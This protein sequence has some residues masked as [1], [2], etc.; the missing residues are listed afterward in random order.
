MADLEQE[1]RLVEAAQQNPDCFNELYQLYFDKIY[2]FVLSRASS[3]ELAEDITSQTFM[4]ALENI[5]RFKWRN[6]SFG[7]W[8]YRIAINNL[9]S[10]FRKH[11]RI[12]LAEEE[13]LINLVDQQLP[14]YEPY[15]DLDEQAR[16]KELNLAVKKLSFDEQNLISLKYFQNKSYE[17]IA[18]IL[19]LPASTVGVK[20]HR[21]LKKIRKIINL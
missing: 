20:L 15:T 16:I 10:H 14:P 9:N 7:A 12:F 4:N 17:E 21:S 5:R 19:N 3:V 6:V 13:T 11:K 8:L 2:N 18:E 1:R